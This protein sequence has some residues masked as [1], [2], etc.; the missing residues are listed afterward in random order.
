MNNDTLVPTLSGECFVVPPDVCVHTTTY[1]TIVTL[2]P[3]IGGYQ[4]AY[5]RCCRNQ[6]IANIID[7]LGTGATYGLTISEQALLECNS[8][9]QFVQWPLYTSV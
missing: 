6:T 2:P 5:Q 4:L 8:S 9:P 3:V 1:T 7:P